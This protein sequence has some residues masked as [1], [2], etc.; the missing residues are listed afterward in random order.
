LCF[1]VEKSSLGT[2]FDLA[3][4]G[5]ESNVLDKELLM[6]NAGIALLGFWTGVSYI[7]NL[8]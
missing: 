7:I 3:F 2:A 6:S 4:F 8:F 1:K 5:K